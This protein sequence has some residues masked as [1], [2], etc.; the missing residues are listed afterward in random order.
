M[1]GMRE[2]FTCK[3]IAF[4]G[5]SVTRGLMGSFLNTL[6][7]NQWVQG[8]PHHAVNY[9]TQG[10]IHVDFFWQTQVPTCCSIFCLA[11]ESNL[12]V[13][14]VGCIA[15]MHRPAA[16]HWSDTEVDAQ[17]PVPHS[18]HLLCDLEHTLLWCAAER[19]MR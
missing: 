3:R 13:L 8:R 15:C 9:T 19:C 6:D 2:L 18:P 12:S 16:A 17:H 14:L 4:L 7:P 10:G 1:E 11:Q 5:D